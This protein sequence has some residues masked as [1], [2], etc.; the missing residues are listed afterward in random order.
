MAV[1]VP[2]GGE[3]LREGGAGRLLPVPALALRV[4]TTAWNIDGCGPRRGNGKHEV[5]TASADVEGVDRACVGGSDGGGGE[6][7]NGGAAAGVLPGDG[8]TIGWDGNGDGGSWEVRV[9]PHGGGDSRCCCVK[10]DRYP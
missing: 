5:A 6:A 2:S 7:E 4:D 9:R 3:V 1:R 10:R 8:A